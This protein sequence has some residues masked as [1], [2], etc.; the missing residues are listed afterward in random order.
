MDQFKKESARYL[1]ENRLS[2]MGEA[3]TK[4][5]TAMLNESRE[6]NDAADDTFDIYRNQGRI[7]VCKELLLML[8]RKPL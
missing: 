4:V 6:M 8:T 5:V 1:Y 2:P 7:A 3:I